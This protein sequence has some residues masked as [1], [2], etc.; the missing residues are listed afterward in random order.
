MKTLKIIGI[1]LAVLIILFFG[2]ALLLPSDVHVER[3]LVIPASSEV[4][5][6]QINDL[7]QWQKWSP[8]HQMDP[9]MKVTYEGESK[10]EGASYS[11]S[12]D[13]VGNGK[14]TI[15]EAHP[16]QYIATDLDFTGQG[17]AR[18]YYRFENSSEGTLVT[19]GFDADMGQNPIAKYMGLMMDSMIGS[20]FEKGLQNL[21]THVQSLP[22]KIATDATSS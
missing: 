1:V 9:N 15:V 2:I 20:D 14:L 6:N 3:S 22:P 21:K 16:H 5:Y 19:W 8:W 17:K 11:W 7:Q 10:G 4:V 12:S 18:A 13:K